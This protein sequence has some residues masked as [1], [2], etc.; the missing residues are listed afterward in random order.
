[1]SLLVFLEK[2]LLLWKSWS[3]VKSLIELGY[4]I[5]SFLVLQANYKETIQDIVKRIFIQLLNR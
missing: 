4:K 1:M 2:R 5:A 3:R